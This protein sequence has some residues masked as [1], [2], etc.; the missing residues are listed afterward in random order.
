MPRSGIGGKEHDTF[1][2][3]S[4]VLHSGYLRGLLEELMIKG[5]DVVERDRYCSL[6]VFL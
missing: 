2:P 6:V 4:V 5:R 3:D 1:T